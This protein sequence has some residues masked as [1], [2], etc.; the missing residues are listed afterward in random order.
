M[1]PQSQSISQALPDT[2][3]SSTQNNNFN[4]MRNGL[5]PHKAFDLAIAKLEC[6]RR[7]LESYI[8]MLK[9]LATIE[10]QY[11]TSLDRIA[12]QAERRLEADRKSFETTPPIGFDDVVGAGFIGLF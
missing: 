3:T 5:P 1:S 12:T 7:A 10:S 6:S 9:E 2:T 11:A 4:S 8:T